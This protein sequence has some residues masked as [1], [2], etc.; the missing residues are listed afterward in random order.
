M[1][2]AGDVSDPVPV[3]D[4]RIYYRGR[5]IR[6]AILKDLMDTRGILDGKRRGRGG[7]LAQSRAA[8]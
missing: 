8:V 1:V 6:D 3:N 7:V 5:Q 4:T 2:F